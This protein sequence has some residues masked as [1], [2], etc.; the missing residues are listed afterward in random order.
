M[1]GPLK[2]GGGG[3]KIKW[4]APFANTFLYSFET[5]PCGIIC[6]NCLCFRL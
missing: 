2:R 4:N 6:V 1:K 3:A 5:I